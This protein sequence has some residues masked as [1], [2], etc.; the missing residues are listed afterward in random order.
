VFVRKAIERV[1]ARGFDVVHFHNPSLLGGPGLLQLGTGLKLYTAH[2]QWLLC[3]SH[4][5]WQH[6][7][8]VCQNPPCWSC[9]FAYGRPPQLWRYTSL[10][11]RSLAEL[12]ALIVPSSTS[13][14]LHA[15]YGDVVRIERLPHF[16][17]R[18]AERSDAVHR[19]DRPFF[20]YVGRLESI[21][22]VET[23]FPAFAKRTEDLVI[24][25]SG[26]LAASLER[27]ASGVPR[28]HFAGWK[29]AAEL[30]ALY[31]DAIA[32][33]VPTRGHEAFGL[34]AVE[35][36]AR[37]T[38]AVVRRFG[39]LA[40]LVV[41]GTNGFTYTDERELEQALDRLANDAALRNALGR[42][43]RAMYEARWTPGHH[44]AAYLDLIASLARERGAAA[45]ADAA[46]AGA[47][48]A[49]NGKV[50][51]EAG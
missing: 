50:V 31:R 13:A 16:V 36:F 26:S 20:L 39:A 17:P 8:R 41:D 11:R 25:G 33:I 7:R 46:S 9:T 37:G 51:L 34:V 10:I 28:V 3:P 27:R 1:L 15:R 18:S 2:E 38:P 30:D 44:V 5:L 40:E 29:S 49:R 6:K 19:R 4:T 21:K 42:E 35:A 12:D 48:A 22:G 43:G 14:A 24:V 47:V 45:L 23:L 32:V